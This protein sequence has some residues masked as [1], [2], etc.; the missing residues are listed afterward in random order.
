MSIYEERNQILR[1]CHKQKW[2]KTRYQSGWLQ[3]QKWLDKSEGFIGAIGF[4]RK[5]V[6]AFARVDTTPYSNHKEIYSVQVHRRLSMIV[7][8]SEE[9]TTW[10]TVTDLSKYEWTCDQWIRA[11]LIQLCPEKISEE[12][13]IYFLFHKLT[14]NTIGV[15]HVQKRGVQH[16]ICIAKAYLPFG[17]II[18][19][20][21]TCTRQ[22]EQTIQQ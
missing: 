22:N 2:N 21:N 11:C 13:P 12:I 18:N 5:L 19:L 3:S 6:T 20:F 9:A 8:C 17:L 10:N 1:I 14:L 15:A 16:Y 4:C 7:Q